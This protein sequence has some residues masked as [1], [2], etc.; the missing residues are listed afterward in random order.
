MP[1]LVLQY[2]RSMRDGGKASGQ[3]VTMNDGDEEVMQSHFDFKQ[4]EFEE[5]LRNFAMAV[6]RYPDRSCF[7]QRVDKP[8]FPVTEWAPAHVEQFRTDPD[9]A[10]KELSEIKTVTYD[11]RKGKDQE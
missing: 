10:V 5:M 9:K 8:G 4:M 11:M 7:F 1:R 2:S 3:I 6:Q